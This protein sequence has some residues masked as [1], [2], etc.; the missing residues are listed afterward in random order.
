MKTL[1]LLL[2]ILLT[3]TASGMAATINF[4]W[5][6]NPAEEMVSGYRIYGDSGSNVVIDVV[7]P[8][9]TT[10]TLVGVRGDHSYSLTAYRV[11][12][13]PVTGESEIVESKHSN[14]LIFSHKKIIPSTPGIFK[15][16]VTK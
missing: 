7:G 10:A 12:V 8:D 5:L 14:Y 2:P 11:E 6:A 3:W 15:A 4:S 13:D 9:I 16:T 1:F